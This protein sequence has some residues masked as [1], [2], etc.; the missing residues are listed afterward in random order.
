MSLTRVVE[1]EK[2]EASDLNQYADHLEGAVGSTLAYFLRTADGE[3]FTIRLSDAAG[4]RKVIIQDSAGTEV[5][6]IDSDGNL[7]ISG[8]FTSA[9]LTLTSEASPTPTTEGLIKW[10]SDDNRI[11]V[12]DS[13]GTK[14]FYPGVGAGAGLQDFLPVF[15]AAFN[16]ISWS[17]PQFGSAATAGIGII[18]TNTDAAATLRDD[19][20][21]SFA[22][23]GDSTAD[24]YRI[25]GFQVQPDSAGDITL[26]WRGAFGAG[27]A[28]TS[29]LFGL[30][31]GT[32]IAD[33]NNFIGFRSNTTGNVFAV[34]DSA[35]SET[36]TDTGT[37]QGTTPH[38]YEIRVRELGTIVEF[39]VDG[40]QVGS[41]VTTNIPKTINL[42]AL[43]GSAGNTTGVTMVHGQFIA[44]V[45]KA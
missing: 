35:G 18:V 19:G 43:C 40:V 32:T 27:G 34:C 7:V 4:Q 45:E 15:G 39:F 22:T 16:Q 30:A 3:D 11:A 24:T 36:A 31:A 17:S 37:A 9:S 26:F 10:D 5:A 13:V 1:G 28:D 2:S 42:N 14:V 38:D 33:A 25:R 12:G 44:Y 21:V 23:P 20:L 8:T 41:D 6:T 29:Q